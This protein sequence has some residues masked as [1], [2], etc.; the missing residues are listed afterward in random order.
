MAIKCVVHEFHFWEAEASLHLPSSVH[1]LKLTHVALIINLFVF[2]SCGIFFT[3]F[4][5]INIKFKIKLTSERKLAIGK[6][7]KRGNNW[8]RNLF[9]V[10]EH[11][12]H[13]HRSLCALLR[14][15][16]AIKGSLKCNNN[17]LLFDCLDL[18]FIPLSLWPPRRQ[19]FRKLY[20]FDGK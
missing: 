10:F 8:L 20:F 13:A 19:I 18:N 1:Y 7:L 6:Y 3:D 9:I 17:A 11:L 12:I 16:Y 14:G 5:Q 2:K 15:G 4:Q